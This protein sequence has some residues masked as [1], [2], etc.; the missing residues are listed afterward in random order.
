VKALETTEVYYIN[1]EYFSRCK[2]RF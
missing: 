2:S 1:R